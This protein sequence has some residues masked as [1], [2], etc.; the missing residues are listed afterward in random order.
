MLSF[1]FANVNLKVGA[2]A[3]LVDLKNEDLN[4]DHDESLIESLFATESDPLGH[5]TDQN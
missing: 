2:I 5:K 1:Y 4:D 3:H